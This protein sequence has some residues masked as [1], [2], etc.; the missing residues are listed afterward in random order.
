[1]ILLLPPEWITK[2]AGMADDVGAALHAIFMSTY[3]ESLA[4]QNKWW[5]CVKPVGFPWEGEIVDF[6]TANEKHNQ[7]VAVFHRSE[8][9]GVISEAMRA[10][11]F[12][13]VRCA[14]LRMTP[15][16]TDAKGALSI[17]QSDVWYVGVKLYGADVAIRTI[18]ELIGVKPI[19]KPIH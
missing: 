10:I 5:P 8:D 9:D 11:G 14:K 2:G 19:D 13:N 7:L 3:E 16:S 1:M 17:E 6:Q 4:E 18:A 15:T 12:E